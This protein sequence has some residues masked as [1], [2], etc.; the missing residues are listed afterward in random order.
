MKQRAI[1]LDRDGTIIKEKHYLRDY[2]DVE[3]IEGAVKGLKLLKKMGF[4]LV[5]ITNQSGIK[6]GL[7]TEDELE[8][9]HRKLE[10]LL[11]KKGVAIDGIYFSPDL[12]FEISRTRKPQTGLLKKAKEE[13][14]L[15]FRGSYS[16][17]DKKED[18]EM[19]KKK[20]LKTILV[21]TGYG[22]ENSG[23]IKPDF[24]A[25]N[26]LDAALWIRKNFLK[27]T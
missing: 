3:L 19:G 2:S 23:K 17:G 7:I 11:L 22:R 24:V 25:E 20:G 4:K 16:I 1:F 5:I 9:V 13:L 12:P 15:Q 14:G 18:I 8:M 26:L 6:R 27:K 10:E 21:L